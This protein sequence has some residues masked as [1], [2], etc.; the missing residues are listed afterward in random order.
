VTPLIPQ[1]VRIFVAGEPA[2]LRKSFDGLAALVKQALKKEPLGGDLFVF[3]NR[4]G[5][6]AK[7][8]LWDRTGWVLL[9]KRLEN[10]A[11]KFPEAADGVIEVDATQLRLLLDGIELGVRAAK[12]A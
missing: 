8:L 1:G 4:Q 5:H 9:Y 12:R 3:R 10:G 11:F 7:A 2:D 6:R